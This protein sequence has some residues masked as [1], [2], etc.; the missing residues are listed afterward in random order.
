MKTAERPFARPL[1]AGGRVA[2][3]LEYNGSRYQGWQ[4]QARP[5]T[6][7]VQEH[8]EDVLSR[9]AAAPVQLACA[10]RTDAGVHA[11]HQ[12]VHFDNP[13]DRTEKAFVFG[14][15]ATLPADIAVKWACPV[16]DDFHA[17]FSAT[18]RRYRYI[19]LNRPL[20]SAH[21]AG[22]VTFMPKPLDAAL[23]HREAQCLLGEQDF[24]AFR[25]A[26]CQSRTPMRNLNFISVQRAGDWVVIDL[27]ANAFLHHMVRNI[28]GVLSAVGCGD[29]S[30]GWTAEVL[31]GRDRS[32]GGVTAPP[33]G[34]YLVDVRYDPGWGLPS[35]PPGPAWLAPHLSGAPAL[36]R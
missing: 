34:L 1:P 14:A 25:A 7:T 10:G 29:A 24:S 22:Q 35:D 5:G 32:R 28:T 2:I 13:A 18:A 26:G 11:S 21:L 36:A 23:M 15:N 31:A 17:R 20:R 3:A 9:V 19:I 6:P 27:Q 4:R 33:H 8:L 30:P 12:V 16:A